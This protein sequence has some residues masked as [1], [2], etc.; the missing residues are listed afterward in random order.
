MIK[1]KLIAIMALLT[2]VA[3]GTVPAVAQTDTQSSSPNERTITKQI[4][5]MVTKIDPKT[6]EVTLE[7][8][9]GNYISPLTRR[10]PGLTSS[11]WGTL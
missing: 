8:P 7:T 9:L 5:A 3:L 6:R 1:P 4:S 11:R 10:Y 2:T